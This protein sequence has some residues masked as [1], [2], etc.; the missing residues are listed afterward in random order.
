LLDD[1]LG[2]LGG[3]SAKAGSGNSAAAQPSA[4]STNDVQAVAPV[5]SALSTQE[6][7]LVQEEASADADVSNPLPEA[8]AGPASEGL[9][10]GAAP[11]AA[12]PVQKE[13]EGWPCGQHSAAAALPQVGPDVDDLVDALMATLVMQLLPVPGLW[14]AAFLLSQLCPHAST[15]DQQ[16]QQNQ[17]AWVFKVSPEQCETL[18]SALAKAATDVLEELGSM[19]CEAVFPL[20][21]MEWQL[22]TDGIARPLLRASADVLIAGPSLYPPRPPS[23]SSVAVGQ[24]QAVAAATAVAQM[25]G[26]SV[27]AASALH[28]HHSVQR[29]VAVLQLLQLLRNGKSSPEPPLP[30]VPEMDQRH[31]DINEGQQV[32]FQPSAAIPC[33]VSFAPGQ[34]RR[35]YFSVA[36]VALTKLHDYLMDANAIQSAAARASVLHSSPAVVLAD[37]A[38]TRLNAG[39]VLSVSPML[40]ADPV[41]DKNVGKW[42]HVHVRPS[43]RGLL[44][45]LRGA[46]GRKGGVLGAM[47]QLADGHWVLAFP[48]AERAAS[49]RNLVEQNAARLR[50]LYAEM[51][52]PV[53]SP[54]GAADYW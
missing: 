44:R 33:V 4:S 34:E 6:H 13:E 17:V 28:V 10:P 38:P 51:L 5:A 26:L 25:M 18:H 39:I 9:L 12:S 42:L 50:S 16:Q 2:A 46:P 15:A 41:V 43:V 1:P 30:S 11:S 45:V 14:N 36:G 24:P 29:L 22:A 8:E 52:G 49:A 21:C 19:W 3:P 7:P 37:P 23:A 27:S 20:I 53:I 48:D 32:D 47:R 31:L 35:V 54:V 40:G